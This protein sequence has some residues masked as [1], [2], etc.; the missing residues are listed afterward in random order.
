MVNNACSIVKYL[1]SMLHKS[2][3]AYAYIGRS[4]PIGP[5]ESTEH[6]VY[7]LASVV[8]IKSPSKSG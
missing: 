8:N 5:W 3:E 6:T 1:S 2:R 4:L 7:A